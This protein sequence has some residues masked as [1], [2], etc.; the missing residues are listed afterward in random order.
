MQQILSIQAKE[1][2]VLAKPVEQQDGRILCG[3]GTSLTAN[4]IDRLLKMDI[5]NITVE[6]HPIKVEG[7]KSL[8]EEL[9]DIEDRFSLVKSIPP[10]MYIKK[11]LMK[12]LIA[13]RSK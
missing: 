5:S 11:R 9:H 6:G 7:E 13:S 4:L 12:K 10:L 2:M 3:K 8:K 1:G